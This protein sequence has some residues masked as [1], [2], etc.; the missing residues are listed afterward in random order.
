LFFNTFYKKEVEVDTVHV[1]KKRFIEFCG[2]NRITQ[3]ALAK[4]ANV[5]QAAVQKW[6]DL[7]ESAVPNMFAIC[8]LVNEYDLS[9][10]WLAEGVGNWNCGVIQNT[11]ISNKD[12]SNCLLIIKSI[13]QNQTIADANKNL[14]ETTKMLAEENKMLLAEKAACS[15]TSKINRCES[16]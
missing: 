16:F 15:G 10:A 5:S 8:W 4:P 1:V 12:C 3:T 13:E 7:S 6:F 2:A 9:T 11:N 14:S